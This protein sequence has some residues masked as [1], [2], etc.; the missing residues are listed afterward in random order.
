MWATQ[1]LERQ[2][3]HYLFPFEKCGAKGE[4][5]SFGFTAGIIFYD[6]ES[7]SADWGLEGSMG[8]S[9]GAHGGYSQGKHRQSQ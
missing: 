4:E 8:K 2:P 1:F 9:Q 6:T 3:N 7:D 5:D